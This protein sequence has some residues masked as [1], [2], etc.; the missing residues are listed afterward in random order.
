MFFIGLLVGAGAYFVALLLW[1]WTEKFWLSILAV[2]GVTIAMFSIH[3]L[4]G[5][6]TLASIIILFLTGYIIGKK[7]EENE[8][9]QIRQNKI[10]IYSNHCWN[11]G[12][13]IDSKYDRLCMRCGKH[14]ICRKCGKCWCDDPR[15]AGQIKKG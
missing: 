13:E 2:I 1:N 15:N 8:Q 7:K 9:K 3:S 5:L 6:G 10:V 12:T 11:C 14:Y 4:I